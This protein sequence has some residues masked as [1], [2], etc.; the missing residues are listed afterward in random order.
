MRKIAE[1]EI[2]V[3]I[4]RAVVSDRSQGGFGCRECEIRAFRQT[5]RFNLWIGSIESA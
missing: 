2:Q 5:E 4:G 3:E 1:F